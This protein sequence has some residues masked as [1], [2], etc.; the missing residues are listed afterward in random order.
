M[1][2]ANQW[3]ETVAADRAS[4][5]KRYADH[6]ERCSCLVLMRDT[7][8]LKPARDSKGLPEYQSAGPI[9]LRTACV[10]T[11]REQF[12]VI[13]MALT[14]LTSTVLAPESG[15]DVQN[16]KTAGQVIHSYE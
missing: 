13:V 16:A 2:P 1:R 10:P 11:R 3:V 8:T 15:G 9:H 12:V 14:D 7:S 5:S 6:N 4:P